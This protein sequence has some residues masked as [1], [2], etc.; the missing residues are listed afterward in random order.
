MS[1]PLQFRHVLPPG[2]L[3]A[4]YLECMVSLGAYSLPSLCIHATAQPLHPRWKPQ[5]HTAVPVAWSIARSGTTSRWR[6]G[7]TGSGSWMLAR[8][9]VRTLALTARTLQGPRPPGPQQRSPPNETDLAPGAGA[10]GAP[11]LTPL[12]GPP[13]VGPDVQ[14]RVP[15]TRGPLTCA[16]SWTS[17]PTGIWMS[18]CPGDRTAPSFPVSAAP[19]AHNLSG[20]IA[21]TTVSL[22]PLTIQQTEFSSQINPSFLKK[23]KND[24]GFLKWAKAYPFCTFLG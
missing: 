22:H 9:T 12:R 17:E 14:R 13:R 10:K 2:S 4:E 6:R 16:L 3:C 24:W 23:G 8:S 21:R 7:S 15:R 5:A 19:G 11:P 1:T 18:C 20:P